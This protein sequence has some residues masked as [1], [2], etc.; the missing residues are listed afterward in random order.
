MFVWVLKFSCL[1][2]VFGNRWAIF[3]PATPPTVFFCVQLNLVFFPM[4]AWMG[5]DETVPVFETVKDSQQ[6]ESGQNEN[7]QVYILIKF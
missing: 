2:D 4:P 3:V 6:S 1:I 5:S 7:F